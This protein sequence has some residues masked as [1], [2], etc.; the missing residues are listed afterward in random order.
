MGPG[1][2]HGPASGGSRGA[3]RSRGAAVCTL[4]AAAAALGCDRP[5]PPPDVAPVTF[6]Q[7]RQFADGFAGAALPCSRE[8]LEPLFDVPAL[9][10]RYLRGEPTPSV[11]AAV[12]MLEQAGVG[13]KTL[14]AWQA[15]TESYTLLRVR[16]VDGQPRPLFRRITED[17][18]THVHLVGYDELMLGVS[19]LDHT[20]RAIDIYT[21]Y[22]GEWL[23]ETLRAPVDA[24]ASMSDEPSGAANWKDAIPRARALQI[25]RKPAE[26][27]AL[28]DS[29]PAAVRKT[30]MTQVMRVAI[31][32]AISVEAYSQ[33]LDEMAATFPG[34]SS[35]ALI[36]ID[37][38]LVRKDYT[39]ALRYIDQVDRAV[40]GDP[41]LEASRAQALAHRGQDG[42]LDAA[43]RHADAA[44]N[45][46]PTLAKAWWA[47]LD[48]ALAKHA[49]TKALA[50]MDEL[51]RQFG[52]LFDPE[53][54]RQTPA[55]RDLMV[56][57]EYLAWE[58]DQL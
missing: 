46:E 26:A 29:V 44:V 20:V 7:A 31:T 9:T 50:V 41:W 35:M 16:M 40:G 54:L 24:A 32:N 48:V 23:S 21:Y 55:Y 15:L 12:K 53:T 10:A 14:C 30:R 5:A 57:P 47:T 11:E 43:Q 58:A 39:A 22:H 19:R 6:G 49:W 28:L 36:Q 13:A 51:H 18:D 42:D 38:A 52:A 27:L 8:K 2:R 45:A 3:R 33:A 56:S 34:D 37:G 4:V 25:A 17:P 1:E